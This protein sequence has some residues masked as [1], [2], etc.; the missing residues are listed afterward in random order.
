MENELEELPFDG[1]TVTVPVKNF[2][3]LTIKFA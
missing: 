2:E 1:R 3:I